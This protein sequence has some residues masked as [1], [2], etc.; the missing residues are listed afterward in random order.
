MQKMPQPFASVGQSTPFLITICVA[1][2]LVI[3]FAAALLSVY[4]ALTRKSELLRLQAEKFRAIASHFDTLIFE[5]DPQRDQLTFTINST[6]RFFM[7]MTEIEHC[8]EAEFAHV[9]QEDQ[10]RVRD[11]FREAKDKSTATELRL[12]ARD[13]NWVWCECRIEQVEPG[14]NRVHIGQ[15][16]SIEERKQRELRLEKEK[17][18]D[19]LT[20]LLHYAAF[21]HQVSAL[22]NGRAGMF[23]FFDSNSL[24]KVNDAYGHDAGDELLRLTAAEIR[25]AFRASDPISRR[26]AGGDEFVVYTEGLS[27]VGRAREKAELAIAGVAGIDKFEG[28]RSSICCGIA[29]Y[30]QDGRT[31]EE[32]SKAADAA[33]YDAKRISNHGDYCCFYKQEKTVGD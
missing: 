1:A 13:G 17:S 15:I 5:Y 8:R 24:K 21:E 11:M 27:D 22:L 18:T 7:D 9:H 16:M 2:V 10:Q 30:P 6:P 3:G 20:G 28:V 33:M 4:R 25:R 32:L 12:M 19:P 23:Y 26:S 31:F 29:R 14:D